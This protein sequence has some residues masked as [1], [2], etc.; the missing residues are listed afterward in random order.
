MRYSWSSGELQ[1]IVHGRSVMPSHPQFRHEDYRCHP[2]CSQLNLTVSLL[3]QTLWCQECCGARVSHGDP[4]Q[5]YNLSC[6]NILRGLTHMS[7]YHTPSPWVFLKCQHWKLFPP[8]VK[9]DTMETVE[10]LLVFAAC[11]NHC[12]LLDFHPNSYVNP[13][14]PGISPL[15]T[16]K[17]MNFIQANQNKNLQ[18]WPKF[19]VCLL[20]VDVSSFSF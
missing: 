5:Q 6:K 18:V 9:T 19:L 17:L 4:P 8:T 2:C 16:E 13:G 7:L 3:G 10:L 14:W 11:Q 20:R 12:P 15:I 1:G